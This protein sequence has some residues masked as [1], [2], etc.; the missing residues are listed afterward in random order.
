[1]VGRDSHL[2]QDSSEPQVC[3]AKCILKVWWET[4][5]MSVIHHSKRCGLQG[6]VWM[7]RLMFNCSSNECQHGVARNS[8]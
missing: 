7:S 4:C 5:N 3:T 6:D 2:D 8:W 1:M